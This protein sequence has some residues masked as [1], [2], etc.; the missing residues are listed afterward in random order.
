MAKAEMVVDKEKPLSAADEAIFIKLQEVIKRDMGAFWNVVEAMAEI[1]ERR[2]YRKQEDGLGWLTFEDY[3]RDTFDMGRGYVNRCIKAHQVRENLKML[4]GDNCHQNNKEVFD[5]LPINE[6]Q[7]R[8]LTGLPLVEQ[9]QVWQMAIDSNKE[10]QPVTAALVKGVVDKYMGKATQKQVRKVRQEA[11]ATLLVSKGFQGA[12]AA[13]YKVLEDEVGSLKEE[14]KQLVASHLEQL[15]HLVSGG[16][17]Q[18]FYDGGDAKKLEKAGFTI[19]RM[20]ETG[21]MIKERAGGGWP[22]FEG[23]FKTLKAMRTAMAG[24]M[25]NT[26]IVRG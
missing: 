13:L 14:E 22:K 21:K 26:K 7:C 3:C 24:H 12:F 19:L 16:G 10:G 17:D 4:F 9:R 18:A 11:P 15:H 23:P 20:D 6:A 5:L 2:L 25:T 8:P 1:R